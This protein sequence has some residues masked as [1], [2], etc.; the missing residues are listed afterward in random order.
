MFNV[1]YILR[2]TIL[3]WVVFDTLSLDVQLFVVD[4]STYGL[5]DVQS[6]YI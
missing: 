2:L 6:F 5:F 3:R 4:H 1:Q